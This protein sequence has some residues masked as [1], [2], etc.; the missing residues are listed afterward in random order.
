VFFLIPF[1]IVVWMYAF[2]AVRRSWGFY[3]ASA[4]IG[5]MPGLFIL[6]TFILVFAV[7]VGLQGIAMAAR[8]ILV[9]ADREELLPPNMRYSAEKGHG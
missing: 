6:K 5:G 1:V 8:S 4:N 2:P 9:L 7:L 3:E